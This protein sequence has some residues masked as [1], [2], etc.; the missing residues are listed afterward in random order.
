MIIGKLSCNTI[1]ELE[2]KNKDL[3]KKDLDDV[4]NSVC[5]ILCAGKC[6]KVYLDK[7]F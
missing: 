2:K 6:K 5:N 7:R 4:K 3:S 1:K